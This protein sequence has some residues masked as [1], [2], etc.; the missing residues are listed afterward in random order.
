MIARKAGAAVHVLDRFH[1]MTYVSKAID[2]VRASEVKTTQG[3][4]L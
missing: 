1:I 3:E 2:E 4:G